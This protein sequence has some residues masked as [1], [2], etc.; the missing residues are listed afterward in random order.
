M[1]R[2][3]NYLEQ[4][5]GWPT[6]G[7]HI[8]AHYDAATIVV[9]QAF[10]RTIADEALSLQRFGPSFS[11][12]RMSWIKPNFLW[13]MFRCGWATKVDQERVLAITIGRTHFETW[14]ISAVHSTFNESRRGSTQGGEEARAEWQQ[15][16][17]KSEVRLQWDPDHGPSGNPLERRALQLGLRGN[18]LRTFARD[19]IVAIEDMTPFVIEQRSLAVS[20][21]AEL[22][23]PR[24]RVFRPMD[25]SASRN[26][27]LD[28]A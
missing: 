23:T 27:G 4:E 1:I 21:Y 18:A 11:L 26:V 7:R 6:S 25:S 20:P 19:A 28:V 10:N 5:R 8:L 24:E 13:M 3:E 14:L 12:S 9:Y 15:S 2:T 22:T 17:R 16:V